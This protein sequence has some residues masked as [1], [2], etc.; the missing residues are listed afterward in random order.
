MATDIIP[1]PK[2]TYNHKIERLRGARKLAGYGEHKNRYKV[3]RL[4]EKASKTR[5]MEI[6]AT[7]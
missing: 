7:M 6:R 2:K 3:Y 5:L 1:Q 4:T